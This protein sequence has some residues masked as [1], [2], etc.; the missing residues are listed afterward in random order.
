MQLE[1]AAPLR[2]TS[3]EE[4][5]YRRLST[6]PLLGQPPTRPATVEQNSPTI[7]QT[8]RKNQQEDKG[9]HDEL[10]QDQGVASLAED[11]SSIAVE[12]ESEYNLAISARIA[13]DSYAMEKV[14]KSSNGLNP[15]SIFRLSLLLLSAL[16][17]GTAC[18]NYKNESAAIGFCDTG[19]NTSVALQNL[20]D[21]REAVDLCNREN[22]T[23]LLPPAPKSDQGENTP[24]TEPCPLPPLIPFPH[25]NSC[26]PCPESATCSQYS[27]LCDTGY[28]LRPHPLFFY[29]PPSPS[30]SQ[31][32]SSSLVDLI[33]KVISLSTDGLP[34]FGSIAFPPRCVEDP[35]RKRHIGS[36]GKAV[37]AVLGQERGKRLCQGGKHL[38]EAIPTDEGGDAKKW[39]VEVEKLRAIMKGKTSVSHTVSP[40]IF[41]V[42]YILTASTPTCV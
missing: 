26:T 27:I 23:T 29:L 7:K 15:T 28:L 32:T 11:A 5:I 8:K 33:W 24:S 22:R 10:M 36:L 19:S 20:I 17:I 31:P 39:G 34:G 25:P 18:V 14:S 16:F 40:S 41:E 3:S 9:Q 2:A 30:P 21:K 6:P 37:E 1:D 13:E 12:G 38:K 42:S 35:K 4:K